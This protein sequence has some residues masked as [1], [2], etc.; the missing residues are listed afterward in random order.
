MLFYHYNSAG[1]RICGYQELIDN[2]G[3]VA[4]LKE[5]DILQD[6]VYFLNPTSECY[7]ILTPIIVTEIEKGKIV[8]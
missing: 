3:S 6:Q 4:L 1:Y 8:L 7:E 5:D 2:T